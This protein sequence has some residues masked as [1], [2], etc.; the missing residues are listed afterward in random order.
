MGQYLPELGVRR[1]E[2]RSAY[3]ATIPE[4]PPVLLPQEYAGLASFVGSAIE[5]RL[6]WSLNSS[7][8]PE[9]SI[10]NGLDTVA[11]YQERLHQQ[12]AIGTVAA[13]AVRCVG[14]AIISR[15]AGVL[16]KH[17]P[18][19]RAIGIVRSPGAADRLAGAAFTM[20]ALESAYHSGGRSLTQASFFGRKLSLQSMLSASLATK[21]GKVVNEIAYEVPSLLFDD[22][23]RQVEVAANSPFNDLRL[24]TIPQN[25][26]LS[27]PFSGGIA[28]GGAEAD[29]IVDGQLLDVKANRDVRTL[30]TRELQQL[31]GYLLLDTNDTFTISSI[32][33]YRTRNGHLFNVEVPDFLEKAGATMPLS[34]LRTLFDEQV[35]QPL[36]ERRSKAE[37]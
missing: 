32:G 5:K 12:A 15:T 35:L 8:F 13:H 1:N 25:V 26:Q 31:A 24:S 34:Y 16:A 19:N 33:L 20:A 3:H 36:A 9:E 27:V 14:E 23:A 18:D 2:L 10:L 11:R 17:V 22:M 21:R 28:L 37:A 6:G 7:L 30:L 29:L 4:Q